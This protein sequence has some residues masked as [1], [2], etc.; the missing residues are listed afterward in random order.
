VNARRGEKVLVVTTMSRAF[1]DQD[2][3]GAERPKAIYG[4]FDN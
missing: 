4:S 2:L 1:S 3:S